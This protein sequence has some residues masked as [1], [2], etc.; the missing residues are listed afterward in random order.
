MTQP[1]HSSHTAHPGAHS[2]N[3]HQT[4]QAPSAPHHVLLVADHF[5]P[6]R[7][8]LEAFCLHIATRLA[9][10]GIV[11]SVLTYQYDHTLP[12]QQTYEGVEI[13]RVPAFEVL[14]NTYCLP[15]LF[16]PHL[17]KTLAHLSSQKWDAVI[18]NTRF[19]SSCVLGRSVARRSRSPYIHIEHGNSYVKHSNPFVAACAWIYDQIF[20][21]FVI[22]SADAVVTISQKGAPFVKKLGAKS[23][24]VIYNSVDTKQYVRVDELIRNRIKSEQSIAPDD[25]VILFVGRLIY[26][27][28]V[29]HL[30]E[31]ISSVPHARLF[32]MGDG[33]YRSELMTLAAGKPVTFLGAQPSSVCQEYI[34]IANCVVNPSY[35]EGIPTSLLEA[36]SVGVPVV[37][38]N[39]GGTKEIIPDIRY[40]VVVEPKDNAALLSA[41]ISL[42]KN[43]ALGKSMTQQLQ[44]RVREQFD[45]DINIAKLEKLI[46]SL[47]PVS[48]QQQTTQPE[49]AKTT[50][51]TS[52]PSASADSV[53]ISNDELSDTYTND[54]HT[55][56][57]DADSLITDAV[58]EPTDEQNGEDEQ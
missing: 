53:S 19:F 15:K 34:S 46:E 36:G 45:W 12:L 29:Q 9:K 30:I 42:Q 52:A 7:G 11:V 27:K 21:R 44:Q 17:K 14:K 26:A 56:A 3:S 31:V 57:R 37:A 20:G 54:T 39:V 40:G 32:I 25:F 55:I 24:V 16:N 4:S 18:T 33:P 41:L 38:T 35:N 22:S 1:T 10:K 51:V 13:Y 50:E 43:K 6:F 48:H 49:V 58:D 5:Y 2:T 28:G 8:G 47:Q 23:S